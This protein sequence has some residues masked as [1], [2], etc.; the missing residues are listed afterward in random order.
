ETRIPVQA[1]DAPFEVG[2][3]GTI[4]TRY[5]N[6]VIQPYNDDDTIN[7]KG[8]IV[9]INDVTANYQGKKALA[10]KERS[11][12]LAIEI[13]ELGVFSIDLGQKTV[14]YSPKIM[15]WFGVTRLDLTLGDLLEKI[16][17]DDATKIENTLI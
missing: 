16:H 5:I 12:Q 17:P 11:L 3:N 13:G 10:E 2:R 6:Y 8:V 7:S 1:F 15:Q 9:M 4:K 14:S